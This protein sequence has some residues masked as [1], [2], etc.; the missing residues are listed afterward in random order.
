MDK[1]SGTVLVLLIFLAVAGTAILIT[2]NKNRNLKSQLV[3]LTPGEKITYFELEDKS[4][5]TIRRATISNTHFINMVF[6]FSQPCATCNKSL[7]IWN[8]LYSIERDRIKAYGI[9]LEEFNDTNRRYLDFMNIQFELYRPKDIARF[10]QEFRIKVDNLAQ[11]IL[12]ADDRVIYSYLGDLD[13][14]EYE[15]ISHI[16]NEWR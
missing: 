1:K 8:R 3:Q 12:Y 2:L 11:T 16:L 7:S 10:R 4:G 15:A 9:I 6:I 13:I 5:N 14:K